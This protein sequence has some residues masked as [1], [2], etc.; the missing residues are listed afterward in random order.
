MTA[1]HSLVLQGIHAGIVIAVLVSVTVLGVQGTLA[2]DSLIAVY[3]AAIGFAG[4]SASQLG[5]LGQAVNGKAIVSHEA[6][7]DRE[8]TLRTAMV[9]SAAAPAHTVEAVTPADVEAEESGRGA[10][11]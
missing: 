5:A 4:A 7:A 10:S 11:D 6:L 9:A 3:G 1:R 8:A 2:S